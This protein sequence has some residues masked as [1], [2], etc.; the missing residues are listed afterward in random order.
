MKNLVRKTLLAMTALLCAMAVTSACS[1]DNELSKEEAP[2]R[3]EKCARMVLHGGVTPFDRA[4]TRAG[5]SVWEWQ[6]GAVVYIQ[7]HCGSSVVRGHATYNKADDI[8]D[9]SYSGSI[10]NAGTCEIYFFEGV[11]AS[12][13]H[14]ATLTGSNAVYADKAG[15]YQQ[16]NGKIA[17]NAMLKPLTSR[18]RFKGDAGVKISVTGV[19]NYTAYNAEENKL[20]TNDNTVS[21]TVASDGYT[22]YWYCFFTNVSN[23]ILS[24]KNSIDG[25]Y[26]A[27]EKTFDSAVL[28][29][30]ESG[31]MTIPTENTNK[32]WN[33]LMGVTAVSL[34][35][36][37]LSLLDKGN[38][39]T[40]TATISPSNAFDKSVTWTSSNKSVATVDSNGKVTAIDKG[41]ATITATSN[42]DGTKKATCVVTVLLS[43][44]GHEYVDLGLTSGTRWATMNVGASKVS[45]YGNYYAWGETTTK[46]SYSSSNY[47]YSDK[48]STLP[49]DNDAARVNWGGNWRMP[50]QS[51]FLELYNECTWKW[52]SQDGKNGYKVSSNKNG[53]SIFLPAAGYYI[54]NVSYSVNSIGLYWASSLNSTYADDLYFY[55]A[56]INSSYSSQR[57]H[58]QS[59]RPVYKK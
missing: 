59:I 56:V 11:S 4:A 8:W 41:S 46:S 5:D 42:I 1:S 40:L 45:D 32:G 2:E 54:D 19:S 27:F 48:P 38:T 21:F 14:T 47:T 57:S 31:F 34:S 6:D 35:K 18:I 37:S 13:K 53:K 24:I 22:P 44:N 52:T 30:G 26:V 10:E 17:V 16:S 55:S 15:Q 43:E 28:K 7:F 58:G 20:T 25:N 36:S 9:V 49:L 23:P 12:D 3:S 51:E 29:V 50:T 39:I 33:V